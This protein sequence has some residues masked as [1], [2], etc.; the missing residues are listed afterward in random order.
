VT[1]KLKFRTIISIPVLLST[2]ILI[3]LY[4]QNFDSSVSAIGTQLAVGG[5]INILVLN[6][7]FTPFVRYFAQEKYLWHEQEG[8]LLKYFTMIG[9][10]P[11][12]TLIISLFTSL[13]SI[14]SLCFYLYMKLGF[15]FGKVFIF[16]GAMLAIVMLSVSFAFVILDKQVLSFLYEQNIHDYPIELLS[17]RLSRKNVIIPV[18]MSFM[19]LMF[20]SS[21]ILLKLLN[22]D[23]AGSDTMAVADRAIGS[24]VPFYIL[25]ALIEVPLVILWSRGT[26]QL[27]D[28]INTRLEDMVSG[29]KDLTKRI[30]ICSVDEMATLSNRI[31][32][33]SDIIRDHMLETGR[34]FEQFDINQSNLS[35]NISISSESVKEIANHISV[36]TENVDLEYKMVKETLNTGKSL[37]EDLKELVGNV[38]AQSGSVSESSAAVEE[39]IASITE[40]TRRTANV[41]E[42]INDLSSIF[43]K[44]EEKVTRTVESVSTVVAYSKSLLEINNLISGIAAQTNLLAMNAAIEAAH[45]GDAGRGFSVVADEIRKLAE[46]T[47]THTKTSSENLKRIMSEIDT[48]LKVAEETG[49][50]FNEM[51][52]NLTLIDDESLSI[53]ETMLEHDRANKLVLDQL[54]STNQIVDKLSQGAGYI[55]SKGKSMLEALVSLEEYSGQSFEHCRGV[56]T[57]NNDVQQRIDELVGLSEETDVIKRKTVELVN[58]F[59]V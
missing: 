33:F 58:S 1:Y 41:K 28:Q 45:A 57:R 2:P 24:S 51:K 4:A 27:Y 3:T 19:S 29:E 20:A 30:N 50:I 23:L 6:I 8:T 14:N 56:N 18:F 43:A 34:M 11:L 25:F 26:G 55:S 40:V 37:I 32:I 5:L 46:N 52:G 38:D 7:A 13:I 16:S 59:K 53:S 17:S 10:I 15:D 47:A 42:K 54:S 21:I 35:Q 12:L 49:A 9:K 36:L 44:G 39:M 22:M 31:N 48:S